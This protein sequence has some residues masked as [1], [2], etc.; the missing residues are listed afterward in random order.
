MS[1]PILT[2]C[3]FADDI[4]LYKSENQ[5]TVHLKI[6]GEE[7]FLHHQDI[8]KLNDV[9]DEACQYLNLDD[10]LAQVSIHVI[11]T[12]VTWLAELITKLVKW[13][14]QD[15]QLWQQQRLT[16]QLGE[17]VPLIWHRA[18]LIETVIPLLQIMPTPQK[19]QKFD[20]IHP[21]LLEHTDFRQQI[22]HLKQERQQL[23]DH[24]QAL[25]V[26]SHQ[27]DTN[28]EQLIS[29]LP[30]IFKHFWNTVRP[31]E[32]ANIL[33]LVDLPTVGSTYLNPS[34]GTLQIKKNQFLKLDLAQQLKI[35]HLCQQLTQYYAL[36]VR[37]EFQDLIEGKREC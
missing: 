12:Q 17:A 8:T 27:A 25:E 9:I 34:A 13:G 7:R 33:G 22:E 24:I 32:L 20:Q 14:A 36:D 11:Y 5:K 15:I 21:A 3:L 16:Q 28:I 37:L 35:R 10:Q 30:S 26:S 4:Q 6:K 18:W 1:N 29:F 2:V 19:N 31:D 23:L